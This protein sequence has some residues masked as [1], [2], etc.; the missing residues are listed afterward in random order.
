MLKSSFCGRLFGRSPSGRAFPCKSS[1]CC[2]LSPAI[3]NVGERVFTFLRLHLGARA[4]PS[5]R[6]FPTIPAGCMAEAGHRG[7]RTNGTRPSVPS[8]GMKFIIGISLV[9]PSLSR[10]NG[11]SYFTFAVISSIRSVIFPMEY[12]SINL[13][14]AASVFN[15]SLINFS[16][17]RSDWQHSFKYSISVP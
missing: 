8:H 2:G 17:G 14:F 15:F 16:W 7:G 9:R 6:P 11:N 3:P 10:M 1:L 5:R 13:L 4:V 12:F